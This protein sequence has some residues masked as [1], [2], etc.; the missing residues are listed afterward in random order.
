MLRVQELT[1]ANWLA[2]IRVVFEVS[3]L[4]GT[5]ITGD[6]LPSS[7]SSGSLEAALSSLALPEE[8][9]QVEEVLLLVLRFVHI[10]RRMSR[11][12]ESGLETNTSSAQVNSFSSRKAY[13]W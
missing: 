13:R 12:V 9:V 4:D 10:F 3:E 2:I 8:E 5:L 7:C 11:Q 1:F 6:E